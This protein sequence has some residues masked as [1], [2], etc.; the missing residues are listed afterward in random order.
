VVVLTLLKHIDGETNSKDKNTDGIIAEAGKTDGGRML[1]EQE[2]VERGFVKAD[3]SGT[4]IIKYLNKPGGELVWFD[5]TDPQHGGAGAGEAKQDTKDSATEH[6]EPNPSG[7][8]VLGEEN[9]KPV[10]ETT[11]DD[12]D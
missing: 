5:P 8:V 1:T 6:K 7:Q 11:E 3:P 9:H 10:M 4:G 12:V 2:Q